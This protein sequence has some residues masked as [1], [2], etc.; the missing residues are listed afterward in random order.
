MLTGGRTRVDMEDFGREWEPWLRR[1][2]P[3]LTQDWADELSDVVAVDGKALR[4]SFR[5]ASKRSPTH[6]PQGV[7][8]GVEADAGSAG[9]VGRT[10]PRLP[11]P[12]RVPCRS[13]GCLAPAPE[14][15]DQ[16]KPLNL[17]PKIRYR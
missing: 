3:R 4:R 10:S 6:L 12:E 13:G 2:L 14:L 8:G 17:P 11:H 1:A 9:S 15:L 5:D 7:R 16:Y